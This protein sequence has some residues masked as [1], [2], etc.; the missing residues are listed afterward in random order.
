MDRFDFQVFIRDRLQDPFGDY[1]GSIFDSI[2][3]SISRL[4][5]EGYVPEA[6]PEAERAP[7]EAVPHIIG[8]ARG[9]RS[10]RIP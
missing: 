1:P 4:P 9:L 6:P 5:R 7:P 3:D 10:P 8:G 2:L